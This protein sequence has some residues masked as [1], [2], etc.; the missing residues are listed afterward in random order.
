[1]KPLD[2]A[3]DPL[4]RILV[5]G[6]YGYTGQLIVEEAVAC[7]SRPLIAGRDAAK[8]EPLAERFDLEALAF[9]LDDTEALDQALARVEL[10]LHCA[11]PFQETFE[12][13][14]DACLR[15]G[16]HYLDITGEWQV[17]AA[18][19]RSDAA[20]RD[21][22]ILV[23]PGVGFDVVPSDCLAAHLARRLPD[24]N[25]LS[26]GFQAIGRPSRGTARTAAR[27]ADGRGRVRRGGELQV[28]PAGWRTRSI[29]FGE[30]ERLAVTIPW[31]DIVTAWY[32]TSIPDIEV[33]MAAAPPM[34]KAMRRSRWLGRLLQTS[35]VQRRL[36]RR[37][38]RRAPGPTAD[39]RE[40][41]KSLLWGEVRNR[42]GE[43]R[44]SRLRAPEG[45]T[46]TA[47]TAVLIAQRVLAGDWA[48]GFHTPAG[49]YGP[50]LILEVAGV[51]RQD[52]EASEVEALQEEE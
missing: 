49:L 36:R 2:R 19:A 10:V 15:T 28:V 48:A 29:D 42:H 38:D 52:E 23:L 51:H 33:Y 20:A 31:G 7:G 3:S 13:M 41:G 45:Y 46:L 34:V 24:A 5:Y 21:R 47:R 39:Q 44:V 22:G 17:F 16:V 26:L 14:I 30:G 1:M 50:D 43:T 37:I 6:A 25:Q 4:P 27:G 35:F 40:R 18:A 11:G 12:P 8:L 32:T 9:S